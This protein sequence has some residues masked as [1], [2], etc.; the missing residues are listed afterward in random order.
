MPRNIT[1]RRCRQEE[2]RFKGILGYIVSLRPAMDA[3]CPIS[4]TKKCGG[5]RYNSED[6]FK[7]KKKNHK[8]SYYYLP[9]KHT[10][11][12]HKPV[13]EYACRI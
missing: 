13:C 11:N 5:E 3:L 9:L 6:I 1:L 12:T 4:K 7:K 8:E 10:Y 2:Q